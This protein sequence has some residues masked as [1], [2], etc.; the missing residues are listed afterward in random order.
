M[1]L[2]GVER[3]AFNVQHTEAHRSFLVFCVICGCAALKVD[4]RITQST[5]IL[6]HEL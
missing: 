5:N 1:S 4:A 6:L 2:S 3:L